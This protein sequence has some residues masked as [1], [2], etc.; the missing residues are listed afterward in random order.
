M[1]PIFLW[2]PHSAGQCNVSSTNLAFTGRNSE[3][4]YSQTSSSKLLDF[5]FY[6]NLIFGHSNYPLT[7]QLLVPC[8]PRAHLFFQNCLVVPLGINP[9]YCRYLSAAVR[10]SQG[11][12][13]RRTSAAQLGASVQLG[14]DPTS[15]AQR[16]N[17][18]LR[19][20]GPGP[21]MQCTAM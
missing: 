4:G 1:G 2:R 5:Y 14:I 16:R 13:E 9:Q 12:D 18:A 11:V 3:R 19:H 7:E 8:E 21:A 20:L 15:S 10:G 6:F 17:A